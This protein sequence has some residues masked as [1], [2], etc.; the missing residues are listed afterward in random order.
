MKRGERALCGTT[1]VAAFLLYLCWRSYFFN[2]DGVAC[3]IAVQLGDFR[4]LVHGNHLAYGVLAWA[5]D[6]AWRLLGYQGDTL[7]TLQVLDALLG[8][9]GAAAF[10]S[11][12][13][14]AGRG[15]REALLGALAL[16]VSQAWWF[17]SLEAQVYMLGA[18]FATLA[19]REALAERPRPIVVG[20]LESAAILGHVGHAMAVPALLYMLARRRGSWKPFAA[21]LAASLAA[22]Y[23]AAGVFAVR[24]LDGNDLRL[25]LLGSAALRPDR[26]FA[27]H[28]DAPL[29]ALWSWARMTLRVFCDFVGM[30]GALGAAGLVLAALP[31]A[32]AARGAARADRA[33]RFWLLWLAGYAAL[34]LTW[35]PSTIVYR[36][37]DLVGLWALAS[38]GLAER[39]RWAAGAL[40]A[41]IL[42]AGPYNWATQIR[43]NADPDANP[44]Y[45]EAR[46]LASAAPADAWVLVVGRD[47]V[48]TPYFAHLKPLNLRYLPEEADLDAKLDA[49]EALGET[50]CATDRALAESGRRAELERYGLERVASRDGESLYRVK[51][52]ASRAGAAGKN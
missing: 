35:E 10:A 25:W 37:S 13:K 29:Y 34:Y 31:L 23:L 12:L 8:A 48:Y 47:Q 49:L 52:A 46:W 16:A 19:A 43:P 33:A 1:F 18:L 45:V 6:R 20:L 51:R 36:V 32:A 3:A 2:F 22:A 26:A 40:A 14:R 50:V 30:P 7:W 44:D 9:A 28:A 42:L 38:A 21:S 39:R 41:W 17:W 15:E 4:H 24:P 27:W 5:F 11:L